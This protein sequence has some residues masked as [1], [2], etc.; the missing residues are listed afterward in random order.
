MTFTLV[1]NLQ[2]G[3]DLVWWLIHVPLSVSKDDWKLRTAVI[4]RFFYFCDAGCQRRPSQG[5]LARTPIHGLSKW[6]GLGPEL[7]RDMISK[8]QWWERRINGRKQKT[9][10]LME[11]CLYYNFWRACWWVEYSDIYIMIFVEIKIRHSAFFF[12]GMYA[13]TWNQK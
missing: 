11:E 4:G 2:F 3:Q 1:T 9:L 12:P 5:L 7:P 8:G 10:S 13:K 6:L